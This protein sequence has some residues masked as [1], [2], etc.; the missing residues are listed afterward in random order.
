MK[1]N[2]KPNRGAVRRIVYPYRRQILCIGCL[3][4]FQSA[5]QVSLA[6]VIK[7]V[8]DAALS[9]G[10]LLLWGGI[11]VA[12]LLA[13]IVFHIAQQWY[14]GSCVDNF[15]AKL[16]Q[17]LL[18]AA[19]YSRDSKLQSFHSGELLSRGIE[20]VSTVSSGV[21]DTLPLLAGQVTRLMGSFFAVL[22]LQP[23]VALILVVMAIAMA[24]AA[25][26]LRPLA[27]RCQRKVR[28]TEEA[29]LSNLQEDFQQLEL[30]QSLQTQ[31]QVEKRFGKRIRDNL[32]EKF[33]R[34]RWV[35][36]GSGAV[37]A[38]SYTG[39]GAVILWGAGQLAAK[40]AFTYGD[41]TSILELLSLFR[42]PVLGVSS[43]WNKLMAV[44]V[45][46]ERLMDMLEHEDDA[47][48]D[49]V[50]AEK[51][52][53]VEAVVF[54]NV[55][56]RYPGEETAVVEDFNATFPVT[57]WTCLT[58]ISGKGKTTLFK[59]MLGL[60]TP[61]QGRVFLKTAAGE[62]LPC[63]EQTRRLFAYVPQDY[64]ML[65]GTVM[66]NLQLVA[67]DVTEEVCKSVLELADAGFIW[68]TTAGLQTHLGEN[69]TG[70]SKGQ[71]Q[72]L[73]IARAIL[74]DRKIFLLDECTSAL[75]AKTEDTVLR[76]LKK[77]NKSAILVTHRPQAVEELKNV[78]FVPM[79]Q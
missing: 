70:L 63:S 68:G 44:E 74:M 60:Y 61:E 65:S 38:A 45:A 29:V 5:L 72:R 30:I 50:D 36:G 71:L 6:V 9:Q 79:D 59:L 62:E 66:E 10:N 78:T 48:N 24:G 55:T 47:A 57:G 52:D 3:S 58:G 28:I 56:F 73:A 64:A 13:V 2:I 37:A 67:P 34:R 1:K 51:I 40:T 21:L 35:V 54:E 19:A 8:I 42:G 77:L 16:R 20:D 46:C 14:S 22:M 17:D 39:T 11:L 43:Q 7:F 4:V 33:F 53:S 76:N 18:H 75:D 69:N 15:T 31:E 41:F 32:K 26:S 12:N 23:A 27:K 25:G 49:A